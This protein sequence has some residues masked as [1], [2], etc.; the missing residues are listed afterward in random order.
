MKVLIFRWR[1]RLAQAVVMV[2][3]ALGL[4]A[5]LLF[6]GSGPIHAQTLGQHCY[7]IGPLPQQPPPDWCGCTWGA[8]Y[9]DR[10]PIAGAQ[11][12]VQFAGKAL[13]TTSRLSAVEPYPYYALSADEI[14]A[15]FGDVV[16]LTVTY[17]GNTLTRAVRLLPDS[18]NGEQRASF[19]F[20]ASG[21]WERWTELPNVQALTAAGNDLW[22]GTAAG[23]FRWDVTTDISETQAT[24][25]PAAGVQALAAGPDGSIWAGGPAGLAR[26]RN[27]AWTT[28]ATGLASSNIR[29]LA[30]A[31]DGSVWAGASG[32]TTGGISRFD[33]AAW[34][35]QPDFN[36]PLPNTV[37][38]LATDRAGGIWVGTDGAGASRWDGTTWRTFRAADGLASDIVYG[39]AADDASAW[40]GTFSYLDAT[41]AYGGAGR[42]DLAN[43]AWARYTTT[44]GLAFDDVAAVAV[45]AAGRVWF[46]TWGGGVS[47][48]D[49]RNWWTFDG[50][51]GLSSNFVRALTTGPDGSL[52]AGTRAGVDRFRP[53]PGAAP[54][55]VEQV[56]VTP[57][58]S[59]QGPALL[60]RAEARSGTGRTIVDY[61]WR[62]DVDGALGSEAS[63]VIPMQRL[64]S[65]AH[66]ITVRAVDDAGQWSEEQSTAV[67]FELPRYIYLPQ[68]LR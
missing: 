52:W 58:S 14:G 67:V 55:V 36:G 56:T 28:Q 66:R 26:Y 51:T 39:I 48:F 6:A 65:G 35:P 61:E 2:L 49:G 20:P 42:Y 17:R 46:G 60:F 50:A 54:P 13:T 32:A 31:T 15:K 40:F 23:L 44:D 18:V 19:A 59:R 22:V 8:V 1:L 11:V 7:D 43:D 41:G 24:G 45:D 3:L 64:T 68:L 12:T 33:G 10:Q 63:F 30:I 21:H 57:T 47:L 38:T 62:S 29:G 34:Q 5:F 27:G 37:L 25:L 9:V 4:S 16:T 53:G